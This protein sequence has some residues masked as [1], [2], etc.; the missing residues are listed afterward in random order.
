M[1]VDRFLDGL[2]DDCHDDGDVLEDFDAVNSGPAD[3]PRVTR[4]LKAKAHRAFDRIW[5]SGRM[6]RGQAYAW[7][8]RRLGVRASEAHM[9]AMD[10]HAVLERVIE[11]SDAYMGHPLA[12]DDFPDDLED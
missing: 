4:A 3:N 6:K 2:W 9:S 1:I 11:V 5:K 7:L 12:A 8:S 10:R